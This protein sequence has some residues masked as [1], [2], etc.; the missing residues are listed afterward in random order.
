[1]GIKCSKETIEQERRNWV[2]V[3]E[4]RKEEGVWSGLNDSKCLS[5]KVIEAYTHVRT[6]THTLIHAFL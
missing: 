6:Y 2:G 5:K 3:T 1:M 4:G